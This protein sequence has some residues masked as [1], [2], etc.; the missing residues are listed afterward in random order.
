MLTV[1][2]DLFMVIMWGT[3]Q[4]AVRYVTGAVPGSMYLINKHEAEKER[5]PTGNVVGFFNLKT[6]PV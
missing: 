6:Q 2:E 4:Q 3:W 5:E 1:P